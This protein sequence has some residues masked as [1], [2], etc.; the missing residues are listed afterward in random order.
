MPATHR[1]ESS[2]WMEAVMYDP[3]E[4]TV[5]LGGREL[6]RELIARLAEHAVAV[7]R[8]APKRADEFIAEFGGDDDMRN[9]MITS[10]RKSVGDQKGY[11]NALALLKELGRDPAKARWFQEP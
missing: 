8:D 6:P 7:W 2:P 1:F 3:L 11:N 4:G 5:E 10:D 9:R